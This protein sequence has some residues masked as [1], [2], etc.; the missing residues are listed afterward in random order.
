MSRSRRWL[1]LGGAGA[2]CG[3]AAVALTFADVSDWL[4]AMAAGISAFAMGYAVANCRAARTIAMLERRME[5]DALTGVYNRV[6]AVRLAAAEIALSRR[7]DRRLV[8]VFVD[9]DHFK[10]VNDR[11]GH[12]AGDRALVEVAR[13]LCARTRR[14]DIVSRF[15]G[16]E[17]VILLRDT[18]LFAAVDYAERTR[19]L[20]AE[21]PIRVGN[22]EIHI[23]VSIGLAAFA[24]DRQFETL[25]QRADRALYAAKAAGRN[26]AAVAL[27]DG[28]VRLV[29]PEP[30]PD[31]LTASDHCADALPATTPTASAPPPSSGHDPAR[32]SLDRRSSRAALPLNDDTNGGSA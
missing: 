27:A 3:V 12:A 5:R 28:S 29:P 23:S 7:S 10:Q 30:H 14:S 32:V 25:L 15:G 21:S 18:D 22:R 13:R 16:E 9:I 19:R 31:P 24:G 26:R 20:V 4:T 2:G 11:F 1:W 17:F 6:A 8:V